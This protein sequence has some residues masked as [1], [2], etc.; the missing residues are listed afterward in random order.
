MPPCSRTPWG[1]TELFVPAARTYA[2]RT[3]DIRT[4]YVRLGDWVGLTSVIGTRGLLA[5]AA[6]RRGER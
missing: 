4:L 6:W 1:A 5:I 2:T 3:T